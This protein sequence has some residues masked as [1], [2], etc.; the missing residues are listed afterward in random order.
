MTLA[1]TVN[2]VVGSAGPAPRWMVIAAAL[3]LI[4][5]GSVVL[6]RR[7]PV[8]GPLTRL[9]RPQVVTVVPVS[10]GLF[11]EGCSE[12]PGVERFAGFVFAKELI[13]PAGGDE[14][15]ASTRYWVHDDD[16]PAPVRVGQHEIGCCRWYRADA[17][18]AARQPVVDADVDVDAKPAI[19]AD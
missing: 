7:E 6:R 13:V 1:V 3:S 11:V 19:I 17:P 16:K 18:R 4:G 8:P 12:D 14:R 2:T 10:K 5:F 9:R 15:R